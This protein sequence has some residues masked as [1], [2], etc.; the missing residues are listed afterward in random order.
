MRR[1]TSI[2]RLVLGATVLSLILPIGAVVGLGLYHT[3]LVHL[4]EQALIAE[5]VVIGEA[6]RD[7]WLEAQG[8]QL[9]APDRIL[10][11]DAKEPWYPIE[12]MIDVRRGIL[13]AGP[14]ETHAV[15]VGTG[16][17][18][19]AGARIRPLLERSRLM[20]LSAARVL[21][22]HG[23]VVAT[24]GE[25]L[26]VC[27]DQAP[28]VRTAL[29]GRYD[30]VARHRDQE[31]SYPFDGISR[32]GDIRVF[33][34]LPILADG[35]VIGI[36]RMSRTSVSAI[37]ALW[38]D[39]RSLL[40]AII[41]S[42]V[43]TFVVSITSARTITRPVREIT[44]AAQAIA[45]GEPR[46][47]VA[48]GGVVPAEVYALS[49]A[50]DTMTAQLSDRAAY[51][52]EFA[53][54]VSH[55]LK[56]PLTGIAGAA[57]LLSEGWQQMND[58]ERHRFLENIRSDVDR[59]RRLVSRLLQLARIQSAPA[60][61]EPVMLA[62]FFERLARNY[63]PQVRVDLTGAPKSLMIHREHL[64]SAVRNLLDNAVRHGAGQPVEVTVT[65]E[66]NYAVIRVR[67]QGPGISEGNQKKIF[68]RFFT[69]ERDHGGTGLGLSIVQA[70]AAT[71]GGSVQ[72]DS[73]PGGTTFVL[74]L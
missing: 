64:E 23:C 30:A 4:T 19:I 53:A 62:P 21:N 66:G 52:S 37:K 67:D 14:P 31:G 69:T 68:E 12:P 8:S 40:F 5:S 56:T 73:G 32:A 24:T 20:T 25:D 10:P 17:D 50:L 3:H 35:K 43:V 11:P 44:A 28:E 15:P 36:V 65:S 33:T 54:N 55:E 18:W 48:P 39:R 16:P 59:M 47:P 58:S 51:I 9:G 63:A 70:V 27:F 41:A 1:G 6:W 71:R 26:G 45:H 34:A 60:E 49:E 42:L 74:T 46:K 61:A 72:F 7:R 38:L 22:A 2:R 13:P 29:G 57:E